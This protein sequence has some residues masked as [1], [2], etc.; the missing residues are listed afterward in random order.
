MQLSNNCPNLPKI[1]QIRKFAIY[2]MYFMSVAT[3]VVYYTARCVWG[4]EWGVGD[5]G[6]G[7]IGGYP[8]LE[9][10]SVKF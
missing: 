10:S 6:G 3:C 1:A 2:G 8:T 4:W 9:L 7:E 5:G